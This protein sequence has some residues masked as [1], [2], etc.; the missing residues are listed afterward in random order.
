MEAG[1]I[2]FDNNILNG[3]AVFTKTHIPIKKKYS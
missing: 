1:P 2:T 3:E